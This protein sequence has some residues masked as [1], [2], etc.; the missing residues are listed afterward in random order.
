MSFRVTGRSIP[1]QV[2]YNV[3]APVPE[4]YK[5]VVDIL[6]P[7]FNT[8][9]DDLLYLLGF[10][11]DRSQA[12]CEPVNNLNP[13]ALKSEDSI[14][15]A[16]AQLGGAAG[17]SAQAARGGATAGGGYVR[18]SSSSG[19]SH[20]E[21]EMVGSRSG[22]Q[23]IGLTKLETEYAT[24][25]ESSGSEFH[26]SHSAHSQSTLGLSQSSTTYGGDASRPP[27]VA[28]G[29]EETRLFDTQ[30]S[31]LEGGR[32]GAGAASS[33]SGNKHSTQHHTATTTMHQAGRG[34]GVEYTSEQQ[35]FSNNGW[36]LLPDGNYIIDYNGVTQTGSHTE[37]HSQAHDPTQGQGQGRMHGQGSS[38][39]TETSGYK[40][41]SSSSTGFSSTNNQ[42]VDSAT[43]QGHYGGRSQTHMGS[44]NQ[45]SYGGYNQAGYGEHNSLDSGRSNS[46]H[47]AQS[48]QHY[49]SKAEQ[50]NNNNGWI[51]LPDNTWSRDYSYSSQSSDHSTYGS[52]SAPT[53]HSETGSSYNHY[54]SAS[55]S[56]RGT[57]S[58]TQ[59]GGQARGVGSNSL[60]ALMTAAQRPADYHGTISKVELEQEAGGPVFNSPA[61]SETSRQVETTRYQ[62]SASQGNS[63]HMGAVAGAGGSISGGSGSVGSSSSSSSGTSGGKYSGEG[64]DYVTTNYGRWVWSEEQSKWIL[65]KG[66]NQ[67]DEQ[68]HTT[69]TRT[70]TGW[71]RLPDGRYVRK[72]S[73]SSSSESSG[74]YGVG[75]SASNI[76]SGEAMGASSGY[77]YSSGS[78]GYK[79]SSGTVGNSGQRSSSGTYVNSGGQAQGSADNAGFNRDYFESGTLSGYSGSRGMGAGAVLPGGTGGGGEYGDEG[80]NSTGWVQQA[81]GTIVRKSSSWASWSSASEH[82]LDDNHLRNVQRQLE[83]RAKSRLENMPANVEPG[84]EDQY[85]RTYRSAKSRS[86]RSLAEFQSELSQCHPNN[87]TIIKC[88]I[89]PL[90]KDEGVVFKV[91]SR[92]FT[93][94]QIKNYAEKVAVSS[95]LLTRVT[96][97]PFS[98]QEKMLAFQTASVTTTVIPSEPGEVGTPWWVWLLAALAGILVLA[99]I[100]YCLYKCGFFK[101]KRPD[102]SPETEPLN[103]NNGY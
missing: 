51:K 7:S 101:R 53:H 30:G 28:E 27:A 5:Y 16:S 2:E 25:G 56:S 38:G 20:S 87:C 80:S 99:T 13:M 23:T 98:V 72:M 86:K 32:T 36:R 58:S 95:K 6:W 47:N 76:Q 82:Q 24:T 78:G 37:Q 68:A 92:L 10:D 57:A 73:V 4:K 29:A 48:T 65:E 62:G 74:Q 26:S 71:T 69:H 40:Y 8:D 41:T 14:G 19:Y 17:R 89:G 61:A 59:L 45:A 90:E 102:D 55:S 63:I 54:D 39:G 67:E 21:H 66:P 43:N 52:G 34:G 84:F 35:D 100:T 70:D 64:E 18:Q 93:E 96:K 77:S 103:G 1:D 44:Q 79:S 94:T 15:S 11:Y 91:R 97:L 3:T 75:N 81:D 85:S 49:S 31:S 50:S 46:N 22:E 60:D 83:E 9:G 12:R 88:S 33:T 42:Q